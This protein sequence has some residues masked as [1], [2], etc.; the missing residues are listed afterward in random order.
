MFIIRLFGVCVLAKTYPF[1]QPTFCY[2]ANG[3]DTVSKLGFANFTA[4][5]VCVCVEYVSR[6]MAYSNELC[7]K[8]PAH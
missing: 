4:T 8:K 2:H 1:L 7:F 6:V 3:A 5:Y